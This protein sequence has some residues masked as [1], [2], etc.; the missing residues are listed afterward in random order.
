MTAGVD[1]AAS[2]GPRTDGVGRA[3]TAAKLMFW[4]SAAA[5]P[6]TTDPT[7]VERILRVEVLTGDQIQMWMKS[8]V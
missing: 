6:T 3:F 1:L 8:E 7:I 2:S 5:N 4:G